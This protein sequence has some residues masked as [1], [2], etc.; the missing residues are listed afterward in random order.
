MLPTGR[1]EAFSDGVYAI[2]ITLLVLELDVPKSGPAV[3][4]DLAATWP[5]F[6]GY[7]V[8]FAFIGGHWAAHARLTPLL[9]ASDDGLVGLNLL[10]LLFVSFLPFTTALL[11]EHLTDSAQRTA[12]VLFGANLTLATAMS[13]LLTVYALR[14][15]S[16]V[17]EPDR[18]DVRALVRGR[19]P[20]LTLMA[21]ATAVGAFLPAVAVVCYLLVSGLMLVSP[22]IRIER[23]ALRAR[24]RPTAK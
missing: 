1:L 19:W 8:S 13:Q 4:H 17:A 20:G 7:L 18:P 9:A 3:L 5:A 14:S 10:T 22:L 6:L 24:R 16:L 15:P 23:S 2:V 11:A 21:A 12:A